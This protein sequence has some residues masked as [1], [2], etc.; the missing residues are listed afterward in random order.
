MGS[1]EDFRS[2][3]FERLEPSMKDKL[4]NDQVKINYLRE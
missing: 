2:D 1:I 4:V 3:R